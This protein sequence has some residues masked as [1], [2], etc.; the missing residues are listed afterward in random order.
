MVSIIFTDSQKL[1]AAKQKTSRSSLAL[2]SQDDCEGV[3]DYFEK[4]S[5]VEFEYPA[6]PFASSPVYGPAQISVSETEAPLRT[7]KS[8]KP[9][10]H[11][12]L[13]AHL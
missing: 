9:T 4:M 11:D 12:D 7:M 8:A 5:N 13:P 2:T 6:V 10:G 1:S 3:R